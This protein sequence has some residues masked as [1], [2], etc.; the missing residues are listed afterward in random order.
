MEE[1]EWWEEEM[2]RRGERNAVVGEG[3]AQDED[4]DEDE[5]GKEKVEDERA[6]KTAS[7]ERNCLYCK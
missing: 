2:R 1:G 5:E 3:R 7:K 4:E 6:K